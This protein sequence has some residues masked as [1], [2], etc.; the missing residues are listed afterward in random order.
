ML[1]LT[2]DLKSTP[3]LKRRA[4]GI[5]SARVNNASTMAHIPTVKAEIS[6]VV[7]LEMNN[8]HNIPA[9]NL[10]HRLA[11]AL[12]RYINSSPDDRDIGFLYCFG[13]GL[14]FAHKGDLVASVE[15]NGADILIFVIYY[16]KPYHIVLNN[17]YRDI[18]V[19]V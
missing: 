19:I 12:F 17:F 8:P 2:P 1:F 16:I 18:I 13:R 9:E 10:A 15:R 11:N 7:S 5:I 6:G 4:L 14:V 3:D